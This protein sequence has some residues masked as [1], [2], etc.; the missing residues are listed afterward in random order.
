MAWGRAR[1][2][3]SVARLGRLPDRLILYG[4]EGHD[5]AAG[6]TLSPEVATA[7]D[8]VLGRVREEIQSAKM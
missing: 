7:V 1:P 3:S 4:I 8:K 2:S 6:E 5:F